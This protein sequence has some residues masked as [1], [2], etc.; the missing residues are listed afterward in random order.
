MYFRERDG[1]LF[2]PFFFDVC[3]NNVVGDSTVTIASLS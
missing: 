1:V 2:L 3:G